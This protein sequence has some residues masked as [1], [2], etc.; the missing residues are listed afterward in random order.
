MAAPVTD[1]PK[2]IGHG[3]LPAERGH[4]GHRVG[5]EG[6][7][8]P[9]I[10]RQRQ[11]ADDLG[12]RRSP[13]YGLRRRLGLRAEFV[14]KKLGPRFRPDRGRP[15][16]FQGRQ[17]PVPQW[18]ADGRWRHRQEGQRHALHGRRLVS[19]DAQRRQRP[20]SPG[21]RT[22]AQRGSGPTGSSR[23][24]S[25]ARRS[26]TLAK[27]TPAPATSSSTST[28]TTTVTARTRPPTAWSWRV[29]RSGK[30]KEH[31]CL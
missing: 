1:G 17:H 11:L 25:A 9:P 28:R 22:T 16:G 6:I 27:I 24:A 23:R 29:C 21:R 20:G 7:D 2:E 18:R 3:S 30:I 26:S 19:M 13:V 8:H 31:G 12:R 5:A 15:A 14:P 10:Q 4:H